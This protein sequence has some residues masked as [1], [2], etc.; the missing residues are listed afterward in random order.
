MLGARWVQK[1]V[2]AKDPT[3]ELRV[4]V[5]W[6]NMYLGDKRSRWNPKRISDPR[7]V[8][9]W[10]QDKIVGKWLVER[11]VVD[12]PDEILWDAFLLF[13]PRAVWQETPHPLS[14]WGMPVYPNRLRLRKELQI[15]FIQGLNK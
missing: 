4:Y 1:E 12:Y 14:A 3:T 5:I 7:V 8:H 10:D 13:G 9:Y 2:L 6:F 11:E 15:L